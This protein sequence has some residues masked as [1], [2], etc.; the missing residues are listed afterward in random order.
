MVSVCG[1]ILV[2]EAGAAVGVGAKT[3]EQAEIEALK[4]GSVKAMC[5]FITKIM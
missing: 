5:T 4:V 3:W 2:H 1:E